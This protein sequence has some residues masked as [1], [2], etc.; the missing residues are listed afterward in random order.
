MNELQLRSNFSLQKSGVHIFQLLTK[1]S[2]YAMWRKTHQIRYFHNIKN[3]IHYMFTEWTWWY[4]IASSST[5]YPK[6]SISS[7][8]LPFV[9][10]MTT[11]EM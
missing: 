4:F 1:S 11:M 2:S 7:G 6:D 9:I 5:R 8:L 3:E 10:K